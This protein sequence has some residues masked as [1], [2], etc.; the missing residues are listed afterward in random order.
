VDVPLISP[1]AVQVRTT[2]RELH[3]GCEMKAPLNWE[4]CTSYP[5]MAVPPDDG[6]VHT[7]VAVVLPAVAVG[8]VGVPGTPSGVAGAETS[9]ESPVPA[10][11]TPATR[12]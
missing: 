2:P 12:T 4:L 5:V 3:P 1:V 6:A 7:T 10:A 9:E 8:A 11:F